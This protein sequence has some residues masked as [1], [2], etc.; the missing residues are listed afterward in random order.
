MFAE[1]LAKNIV[2]LTQNEYYFF[3]FGL[4]EE[5]PGQ[6]AQGGRKFRRTGRGLSQDSDGFVQ[7]RFYLV[8]FPI[9]LR[10][11]IGSRASGHMVTT[12]C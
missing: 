7:I 1:T 8:V 9:T 11:S 10:I 4:N 5:E 3:Q 6:Q 12:R 2:R